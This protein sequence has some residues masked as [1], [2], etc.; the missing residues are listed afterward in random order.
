MNR[1]TAS[2][3]IESEIKKLSTIKSLGPDDFTGE[4]YQ[5]VKTVKTVIFLS[6]SKI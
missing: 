5:T 4:L 2:K 1:T 3:Q 6:Y